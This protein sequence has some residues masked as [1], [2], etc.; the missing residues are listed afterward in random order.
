[1]E[2]EGEGG[3]GGR[4]S[5]VLRWSSINHTP[6][7]SVGTNTHHLIIPGGGGLR[8]CL[9]SG[10]NSRRMGVDK[11]LLRHP[12]GDTWL[13]RTLGLLLALDQPVTLLSQHGAHHSL[14]AAL[15]TRRHAAGRGDPPLTLIQEPPPREGPLLALA[16]LMAHHPGER[17]LLC[18]V[19]MPWLD[20]ACL[21]RLLAAAAHPEAIH[22]AHDGQ[23]LQPLLAI[24]PATAARERR[25]ARVL[26]SGE[27]RLMCW[28][29]G[30]DW[31]PVPLPA[32]TLRN[33][34]RPE[35]L[36]PDVVLPAGGGGQPDPADQAPPHASAPRR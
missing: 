24:I 29:A 22:L 5:V 35:E 27:R 33:S 2:T 6:A 19:D 3:R 20:P 10:G 17:L 1:M 23:R 9:L 32:L 31:R 21:E 11:A 4:K 14:A 13:E 7:L 26:A 36:P 18:P 12:E 16:R 8:G 15:I 34:N 30:E 28:L 25:L